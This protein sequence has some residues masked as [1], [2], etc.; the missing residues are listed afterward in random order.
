[1]SLAHVSLLFLLQ[2]GF[3][4]L[5]TFAVNDR[6]A[7]GPKYFK[8]G[9]WVLLGL[10]GLAGS[11]AW[12]PALSAGATPADKQVGCAVAAVA[13][14]TLLFAS[15]SGWDRPRLETALLWTALLAGGLAVALSVLPSGEPGAVAAHA[16]P[17]AGAA[18]AAHSAGAAA[19]SS[20]ALSPAALAALVVT[21]ALGS[22]LVLGFT[23]WGM[24]LGHWYLVSHG[25]GVSHLARLVTPLPWL[26][27]GKAAVSGLALLLLWPQFL[28]PGNRGLGDIVERSPER[29]LDVVNVWARIPVGLLVPA[30]MAAMAR[31]TVRM[32]RT[33]PATGILYAMTVLVLLGELFGKMVAGSTG[34]PL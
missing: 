34:V 23:L 22:A 1:M 11:L 32:E 21:A 16:A 15:V 4:S 28:G 13:A 5:V 6:R 3:G 7:L 17:P 25:L 10:Y 26:L 29:I 14:A 19:V 33:Q 12:G 8:L 27:L 30:A 9:G 24:I 20:G 31:V 18:Q 2:L